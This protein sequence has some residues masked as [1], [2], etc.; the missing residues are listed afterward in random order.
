METSFE[1]GIKYPMLFDK[2]GDIGKAYDV[3]DSQNG[4]T[5]RGTFIIGPDG[6]IYSAEVL[7]SSVGRSIGELLR[8]IKAFQTHLATGNLS[9]LLNHEAAFFYF[10][11]FVYIKGNFSLGLVTLLSGNK[12]SCPNFATNRPHITPK[13]A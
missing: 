13:M 1:G 8:K 3:Y 5:L 7:N 9:G 11:L 6:Y 10:F 4:K 12:E 2:G